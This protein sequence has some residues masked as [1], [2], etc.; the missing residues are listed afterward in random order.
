MSMQPIVGLWARTAL[1]WFLITICFGMYMGMTQ[2]F[3]LSPSHA[4]M[5]LLG[6]LSAAVFAFLYGVA[7]EGS[8]TAKAPKLHWAL[9]NLGVAAMTF[10]LL[11]FLSGR[12]EGW[13]ILIPIGGL[14]VVIAAIW[15]TVMLWAR[16]AAR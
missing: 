15:L 2:Q 13:E 12:G 1:V 5:G 10:A 4:H 9:H 11:M 6:W 7:R 16:L 14:L 8:P 3:H